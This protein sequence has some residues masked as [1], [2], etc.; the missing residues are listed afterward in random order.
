MLAE[1]DVL[2]PDEPLVDEDLGAL[3][4]KPRLHG[5]VG[6]LFERHEKVL[7]RLLHL[8]DDVR[9]RRTQAFGLLR[10]RLGKRGPDFRRS[11]EVSVLDARVQRRAVGGDGIGAPR[12][13]RPLGNAFGLICLKQTPK[14]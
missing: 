8:R 13:D 9:V 14:I 12:G 11:G 5:A 2:R 4:G 1:D 10:E 3:G 6:M 7:R